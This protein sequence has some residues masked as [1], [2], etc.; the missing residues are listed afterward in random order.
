MSDVF[1][2]DTARYGR[3]CERAK[4]AAEA[5]HRLAAA[6]GCSPAFEQLLHKGFPAWPFDLRLEYLGLKDWRGVGELKRQLRKM[7]RARPEADVLLASRSGALFELA[8]SVMF[9]RCRRVLTTDLEWPAYRAAVQAAAVRAGAAVECL[10]L[11]DLVFGDRAA[12]DQVAALVRDRYVRAGCD[13]LFLSSVTNT[14][15]RLPVREMVEPLWRTAVPPRFT[16]IDGTQAPGHVDETVREDYCS[17][18]LTGCHKWLRAQ[19]PLGVAVIPSV[20]TA[21]RVQAVV[22]DRIAGGDPLDPLLAFSRR[23]EDR[24]APPERFGETVNVAPLFTARAALSDPSAELL[25]TLGFNRPR[26]REVATGTGW[27]PVEPHTGL[28]TG[29]L[30]LRAAGRRARTAKPDALRDR[31]HAAGVAI[32]AYDGGVIRLSTP[33]GFPTEGQYERLRKALLECA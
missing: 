15:V 3:M 26:L 32:T 6:E 1:Y 17:F 19:H 14:G 7:L 30:L 2:L 9:A 13:G 21:S 25:C 10:S 29:I 24:K 5:F 18:Y 4:R 16:L 27:D 23:L 22:R 11:R 8:L 31:F 20:L 28:S 12:P 33:K